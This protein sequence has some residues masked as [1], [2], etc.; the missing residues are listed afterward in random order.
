MKTSRNPMTVFA[1]L[2]AMSGVNLGAMIGGRT[3]SARS[4]RDPNSNDS[5]ERIAN[6]QAKRERKNALRLARGL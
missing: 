2:L 3:H 5:V 4:L 1:A 6:A